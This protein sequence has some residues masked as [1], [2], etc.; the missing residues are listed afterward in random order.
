MSFPKR[1]NLSPNDIMDLLRLVVDTTIFTHNNQ[2]YKQSSG[3][4]MG[5]GISPGACNTYMEKFEGQALVSCPPE[6]KPK[7]WLRYVDDVVEAIHRDKVDEFTQH[8]NSLNPCIQFTVE[9]QSENTEGKQHLPVL[10]VDIHRLEDGKSKFK[11][12]RKSTHTDQYLNFHSHH[13]LNQKLGVIRTLFDRAT[14]LTTTEEDKAIEIQNIKAALR[15]C[16]YPEWSFEKVEKMLSEKKDKT[17]KKSKETK[18]ETRRNAKLVVLPYVK[19]LSET[20]A[21]IFRK[22]DTTV[23]FRPANTLGQ[24]LVKLKDKADPLKQADAIYKVGCKNCELSYIGETT[25]PLYVRQKEHLAESEKANNT[26]SFTRQ[27]RKD[28]VTSEFKSALAEHSAKENHVIDWEGVKTL[29]TVNDWH[30]RGIKEAIHIRS[31]PQNMNRVQGERYHLPSV[32][33]SLLATTSQ[34]KNPSQ[35]GRGNT[36]RGKGPPRSSRGTVRGRGGRGR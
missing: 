29:E 20:A 9:L 24:Q 23:C 4:P 13:P 19:G 35:A 25:R 26:R 21:R 34:V 14:S 6:F 7:I 28:S 11:V 30:M 33:N 16:N 22:F 1:T 32:W 31:T 17:K 27:K 12:Y 15:L 10:D 5:S 8:L 3:F 18:S 36:T 2:L